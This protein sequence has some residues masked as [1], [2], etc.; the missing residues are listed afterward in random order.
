MIYDKVKQLAEAKGL[1]IRELEQ[2]AGFGNG[3]VGKWRDSTPSITRVL[4]VAEV[5]GI[6]VSELLDT[7]V[8]GDRDEELSDT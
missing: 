1:T 5:L 2:Q 3:T 8:R 6:S 4:K 7:G